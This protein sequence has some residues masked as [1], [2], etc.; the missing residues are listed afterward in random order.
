MKNIKFISII[1][2]LF[3]LVISATSCGIV[4]I[5]DSN[6]DDVVEPTDTNNTKPV[7]EVTS[8]TET[9]TNGSFAELTIKGKPNTK[10]SI[11]VYYGTGSSDASGLEAS[12]T[13]EN[14]VLTWRWKVGVNTSAG[15][16]KIVISGGDE[17]TTT[18]FTTKS[19]T[20]TPETPDVPETPDTPVTPDTP[21]T[22]VTPDVTETVLKITKLTE[23]VSNGSYAEITISGKPNTE[24]SISVYY[25]S[26][27][28]K[29]KGLEAATTDENG[30]LTWRW[31]VGVN[32]AEGG[33]KITI[34]GGDETIDT[35]FTT[36]E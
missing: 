22:P 3:A 25:G 19:N 21:D 32:T 33:H 9:V 15:E 27:P 10:Y 34:S 5:T 7:L 4:T 30:V 2:L 17:K 20:T 14:G 35:S 1:V 13:D 12:T 29:A 28:S 16:H 8:L 26:G 11:S 6:D 23:I 36:Y 31:R 24:Y 18:Y